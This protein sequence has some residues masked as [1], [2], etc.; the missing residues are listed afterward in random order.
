MADFALDAVSAAVQVLWRADAT[1]VAL[2][3]G[4]MG[5]GVLQGVTFPYLWYEVRERDMRGLGG[6]GLPEV[7]LRAHI[8]STAPGMREAQQI[9][10]RLITVTKD[11]TLTV[12]GY[13]QCGKVFYDETVPIPL[14]EINGVPVRELV[15]MFRIY[16]EESA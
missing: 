12:S 6:G 16:V 4:R 2:V 3:G 1:L 9:A 13:T 10:S 8:F 15:P 14:S 5:D 11:A 7:E